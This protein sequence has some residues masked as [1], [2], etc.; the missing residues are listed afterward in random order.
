MLGPW[1]EIAVCCP[2]ISPS[3]SAAFTPRYPV[4][5]AG[6]IHSPCSCTLP[7]P[8]PVLVSIPSSRTA[9][10]SPRLACRDRCWGR[11]VAVRVRPGQPRSSQEG[12]ASSR[13]GATRRVQRLQQPLGAVVP[14]HL[15]LPPTAHKPS[16]DDVAL[17]LSGL[18][19]KER[20]QALCCVLLASLGGFRSNCGCSSCSV[21]EPREG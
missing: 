20:E 8:A 4:L 14:S 21:P 3:E 9:R 7:C 13:R 1:V 6:A 16:G 2:W 17:V 12:A 15:V 19:R 11:H 10:P 18:S 5:L